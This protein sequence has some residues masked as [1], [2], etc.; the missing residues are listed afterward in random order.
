MENKGLIW[1]LV[2][3]FVLAG[4]GVGAYMLTKD[5]ST[6]D[7]ANNTSQTAQNEEAMD[8][9]PAE[10]SP[11]VVGLAIATP[12]LSTLVTAV[13]AAD[14][15]DTL[16][17]E[18]PFTVLAPTNEAFANLPAGTLNSLLLPENKQKL[19][20]ILTYHVI[21]GNVMSSD[22]TN[23]QIVK[24]V[25]GTDLTVEI[26][27][28]GVYFVDANGGKAKVVTADVKGSNGTVHIISSVLLP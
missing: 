18:G 13:K 26:N 2:G 4:I 27:D 8:N 11:T 9:K 24:T 10:S 25:N 21:A 23:G 1:T 28:T 3:I 17:A 14:L 19:A 12:D 5:D 15:V 6:D 16:S 20:D 7:Q 22:L